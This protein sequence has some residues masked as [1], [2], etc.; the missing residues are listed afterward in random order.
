M[1][2][3]RT[4]IIPTEPGWLVWYTLDELTSRQRKWKADPDAWGL[5]ECDN[6]FWL[7]ERTDV[8]GREALRV[9]FREIS[10]RKTEMH[11]R[12]KNREVYLFAGI[13]DETH[14]FAWFLLNKKQADKCF[15]EAAALLN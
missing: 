13:S 11:P 3:S 5:C 15:A 1:P 2:I 7:G 8:E 14:E 10:E 9:P 4:S 12:W 6:V